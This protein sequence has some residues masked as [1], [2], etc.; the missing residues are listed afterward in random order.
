MTPLPATAVLICQSGELAGQKI[1]LGGV[2]TIGCDDKNHIVVSSDTPPSA[3]QARVFSRPLSKRYARIVSKD[4]NFSLEKFAD[5]TD[6]TVDGV[7]VRGPVALDRLHVIGVAGG[8]EFVFRRSAAKQPGAPATPPPPT[9]MPPLEPPPAQTTPAAS[10][11]SAPPPAPSPPPPSPPPAT[12][13][14]PS[15]TPPKATVVDVQ[16][17]GALPSLGKKTPVKATIINA[18]G[19]APLPDLVKSKAP[20]KPTP[21]KATVVQDGGFAPLP[22]LARSG[23]PP[24]KN[25]EAPQPPAKAGDDDDA[26]TG[27]TAILVPPVP[28]NSFEVMIDI[29]GGGWATFVLRLGDNTIGRG[30][31]CDI[32]ISDPAKRLS[33]KHAKLHVTDDRVELIDLKGGNGTFVNGERITTAVLKPGSSFY[34]GPNHKF[35]LKQR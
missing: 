5:A 33:R 27:S 20:T 13:R 35:T 18:G 28:K 26:D 22:N 32:H 2:T 31:D 3:Q 10:P 30:I 8:V 19:F 24:T 11:P 29:P 21:P 23:A 7:A 6:V 25:P 34:L 15:V 17:F 14:P 16:G 12:P 9:R 4:G 1:E